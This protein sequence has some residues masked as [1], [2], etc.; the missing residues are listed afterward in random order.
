LLSRFTRKINLKKLKI[1]EPK[2]L[3]IKTPRFTSKSP[4]LNQQNPSRKPVEI[5]KPPGKT[6]FSAPEKKPTP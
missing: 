6:P 2:K 1:T 4:Q 3:S 5:A